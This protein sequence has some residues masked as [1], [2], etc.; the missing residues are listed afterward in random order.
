MNGRSRH[1]SWRQAH[2]HAKAVQQGVI[3]Q[4]AGKNKRVMPRGVMQLSVSMSRGGGVPRGS[5]AKR[6]H[7]LTIRGKQIALPGS[8]ASFPFV[9]ERKVDKLNGGWWRDLS[10]AMAVRGGGGL[11]R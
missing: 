3:L 6:G 2:R 7:A 5:G 9:F 4:P 11:L 1:E 10:K 8:S